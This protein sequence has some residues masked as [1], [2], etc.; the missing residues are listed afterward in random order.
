MKY[1]YKIVKGKLVG[2]GGPLQSAARKIQNLLFHGMN[3]LPIEDEDKDLSGDV[4][5]NFGGCFLPCEGEY[6]DHPLYMTDAL[7]VQKYRDKGH[8]A[9]LQMS[10]F[11]GGESNIDDGYVGKWNKKI[12]EKANIYYIIM[13]DGPHEVFLTNYD[14]M[15]FVSNTQNARYIVNINDKMMDCTPEEGDVLFDD[16]EEASK[17]FK[18]VY[19]GEMQMKR[20]AEAKEAQRLKDEE[21]YGKPIESLGDGTYIGQQA[22]CAFYYQGQKYKSPI[23]IRCCFPI[24]VIVDIKD[25]KVSH[26]DWGTPYDKWLGK[27]K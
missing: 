24:N 26:R 18:D 15:K 22:G 14:D 20:E 10:K 23:G 1:E 17:Y 27:N 12:S 8:Y 16:F 2:P 6:Q 3:N 9:K 13:E 25:G 21:L 19:I 7:L 5:Y 11:F 4:E